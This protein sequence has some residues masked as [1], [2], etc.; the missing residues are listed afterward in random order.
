MMSW[1]SPEGLSVT[2]STRTADRAEAE[3]IAQATEAQL[4]KRERDGR[5][6][7]RLV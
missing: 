4:P 1:T 6:R 5:P 7:R 2:R 3:R